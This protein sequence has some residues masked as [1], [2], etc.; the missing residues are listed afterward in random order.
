V[1]VYVASSWRCEW[2]PGVVERLR[3]DGHDVYDFR[4]PAPGRHGFAWSEIDPEWQLWG[5]QAYL[6]ALRHPIAEAGFALDRDA[7]RDAD[8]TV[9]VMPCG[10]SA[11]LE[12]GYACGAG[13]RTAILLAG[14][15]EPEL[16]YLLADFVT[17]SLEELARWL[18]RPVAT[19]A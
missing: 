10:R 7:L 5:W 14:D 17:A 6:A 11:H 12:L 1:R 13:Q 8:A 15:E 18:R 4:N 16:M 2:Q 9:L 19:R 3:E